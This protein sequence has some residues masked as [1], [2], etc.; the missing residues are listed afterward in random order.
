M[1]ILCKA[2]C[3][4]TWF[5]LGSI[6]FRKQDTK[7]QISQN[8]YYLRRFGAAQCLVPAWFRLGSTWFPLVPWRGMHQIL[9][10]L[11][12]CL[13]PAWCRLSSKVARCIGWSPHAWRRL[14]LGPN[15]VPGRRPARTAPLQISIPSAGATARLGQHGFKHRRGFFKCLRIRMR[16][17]RVSGGL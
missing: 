17:D 12:A 5:H 13:V 6:R 15:F 7:P 4:F 16:K 14:V 1:V 11:V 3:K 2:C 10:R 8:V 9:K